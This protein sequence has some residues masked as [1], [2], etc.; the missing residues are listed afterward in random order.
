MII[1]YKVGPNSFDRPV[2]RQNK[3][4]LYKIFKLIFDEQQQNLI[5]SVTKF[6]KLRQSIFIVSLGGEGMVGKTNS[7]E[8]NDAQKDLLCNS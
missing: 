6:S 7:V 2:I 5:Q 8:C 3:L 1:K 4:I